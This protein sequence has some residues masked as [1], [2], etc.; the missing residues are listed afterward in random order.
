MN[1]STLIQLIEQWQSDPITDTIFT[2][3]I[4]KNDLQVCA[5][6][7]RAKTSFKVSTED[8]L[9]QWYSKLYKNGFQEPQHGF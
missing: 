1:T 9:D 2:M 4:A 6:D 8:E 7:C 5:Y 3:I